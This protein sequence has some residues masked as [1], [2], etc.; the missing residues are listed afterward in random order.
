M[1]YFSQPIFRCSRATQ[2]AALPQRNN[3]SLASQLAAA[4]R[5]DGQRPR[6]LFSN[7]GFVS[8]HLPQVFALHPVP[9]FHGT[10]Q[11]EVLGIKSVYQV[12]QFL[13]LCMF[14]RFYTVVRYL[15]EREAVKVT[16]FQLN[17]I[18]TELQ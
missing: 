13:I 8:H 4:Y 6:A 18:A 2:R 3:D 1:S 12:E 14:L 10:F 15:R 9:Y 5:N 11:L 17:S 7:G 16:F